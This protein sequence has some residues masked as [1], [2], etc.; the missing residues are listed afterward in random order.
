VQKLSDIRAKVHC[1]ENDSPDDD[2]KCRAIQFQ[3]TAFEFP[4]IPFYETKKNNIFCCKTQVIK[5]IKVIITS[6]SSDLKQSTPD[7]QHSL[8]HLA[9]TLTVL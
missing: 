4:D 8:R 5:M 9:I 6:I 2:I 7:L 3:S 1:Y